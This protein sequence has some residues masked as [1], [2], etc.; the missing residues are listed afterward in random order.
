MENLKI[1]EYEEKE[2]A[3][4]S[5]RVLPSH[6]VH[7]TEWYGYGTIAGRQAR[8]TYLTTEEDKQM[9]EENGGDWSYVDWPGSLQC[10][11]LLDD[12]G[13]EICTIYP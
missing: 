12:D 9:V 1:T 5:N 3:E 13:F 8:A 11:E 7:L 6:M 10:V 4:P 2:G